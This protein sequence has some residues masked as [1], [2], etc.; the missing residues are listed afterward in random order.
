MV[1]RWPSGPEEKEPVPGTGTVIINVSRHG[2]WRAVWQEGPDH[3]GFEGLEEEVRRWG[4]SRPALHF[5]VPNA[6]KDELVEIDREGR[7]VQD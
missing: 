7:P 1:R 5:Y 4:M 3:V 2:E 6:A